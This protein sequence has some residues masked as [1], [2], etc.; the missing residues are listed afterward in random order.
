MKVNRRIFCYPLLLS[1]LT[2]SEGCGPTRL[3]SDSS[4]K[5][6]E[7]QV[8]DC[9]PAAVTTPAEVAPLT[10]LIRPISV[11]AA[12]PGRAELY[13]A[14]L[15]KSILRALQTSSAVTLVSAKEDLDQS[16]KS[17]VLGATITQFRVIYDVGSSGMDRWSSWVVAVF[18]RVELW[19]GTSLSWEQAENGLTS[20][21]MTQ[22]DVLGFV[23]AKDKSIETSHSEIICQLGREVAQ[24]LLNRVASHGQSLGGS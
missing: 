21:E 10:V 24:E 13:G 2:L 11:N 17:I 19:D 15:R 16:E 12:V 6:S 9:H 20:S 4:A 23:L 18:V 1:F 7:N 8:D 3:S 22:V 14:A 5:I